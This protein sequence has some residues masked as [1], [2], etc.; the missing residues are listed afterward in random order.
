MF[1]GGAYPSINMATFLM[2]NGRTVAELAGVGRGDDAHGLGFHL[3]LVPEPGSLLLGLL[4][5]VG[6]LALIKRQRG[7][8]RR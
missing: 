4:G 7:G 5:L 3:A 6:F 1:Q 8:R 2:S